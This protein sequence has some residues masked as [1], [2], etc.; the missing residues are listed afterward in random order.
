[1]GLKCKSAFCSRCSAKV[2]RIVKVGTF[3]HNKSKLRMINPVSVI[4]LWMS[5]NYWSLPD[6]KYEKWKSTSCSFITDLLFA[7]RE[8]WTK[9][10][11]L[12]RYYCRFFTHAASF[13]YAPSY[14]CFAYLSQQL[15]CKIFSHARHLVI[16]ATSQL[17]S[18]LRRGE[19]T[20]A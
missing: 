2:K 3:W 14:L 9:H 8:R 11:S 10:T 5:I 4:N 6:L 1:M 16:S 20:P 18:W 15:L 13:K 12:S 19:I 17:I 7:S